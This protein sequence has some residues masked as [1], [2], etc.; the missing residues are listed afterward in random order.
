MYALISVVIDWVI[1]WNQ[2]QLVTEAQIKGE[3]NEFTLWLN[4]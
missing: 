1:T 4:T 2:K 3:A